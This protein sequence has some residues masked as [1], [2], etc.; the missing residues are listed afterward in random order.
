[1]IV[2]NTPYYLEKDSMMCVGRSLF[3]KYQNAPSADNRLSY[4]ASNEQTISADSMFLVRSPRK[5]FT[6]LIKNKLIIQKIMRY[7]QQTGV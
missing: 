7:L 3:L 2:E 1:M 4:H 6:T 5:C